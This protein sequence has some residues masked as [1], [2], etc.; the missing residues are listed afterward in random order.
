M[1]ATHAPDVLPGLFARL[2]FWADLLVGYVIVAFTANWILSGYL[3]VSVAA[4]WLPGARLGNAMWKTAYEKSDGTWSG[5]V[6]MWLEVSAMLLVIL[7]LMVAIWSLKRESRK[8]GVS[9]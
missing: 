1:I 4:P 5:I 6:E 2:P 8:H 9:S 3:A 7:I